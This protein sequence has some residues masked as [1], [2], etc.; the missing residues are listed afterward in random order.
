MQC[1]DAAILNSE[2]EFPQQWW[3]QNTLDN[4]FIK[5]VQGRDKGWLPLCLLSLSISLVASVTW[6]AIFS[7]TVHW[8]I[9]SLQLMNILI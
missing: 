1:R 4:K 7:Y 2:A 6:I 5:L 8:N 3:W 9:P